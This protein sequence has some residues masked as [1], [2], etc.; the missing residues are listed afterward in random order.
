MLV[1]TFAP[2][3][4][5]N[6]FGTARNFPTSLGSNTILKTLVEGSAAEVKKVISRQ[7]VRA[8]ITQL[9]KLELPRETRRR[10]NHI[11]VRCL[12]DSQ[13]KAFAKLK[14]FPNKETARQL[15]DD[16][17]HSPSSSMGKLKDTIEDLKDS[18]KRKY[19]VIS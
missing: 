2:S 8:S 9:Q 11:F 7:G 18:V 14:R 1:S 15:V 10:R 19:H 13:T 4:L 6:C 5:K 16:F 12:A 3:I 17:T